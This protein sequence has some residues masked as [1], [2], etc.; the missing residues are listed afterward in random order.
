[1]PKHVAPRGSI[2]YV[3][4]F[5]QTLLGDLSV[6]AD[7]K[8][9]EAA[10]WISRPE[11]TLLFNREDVAQY[12]NVVRQLLADFAKNE[13]LSRRS[14]EALLEDAIFTAWD[15]RHESRVQSDE[16]VRMAAT[17]LKTRLSAKPVEY[18]VFVPVEGFEPKELP[19]TFGGIRFAAFGSAQARALRDWRPARSKVWNELKQDDL[20]KQPSAAAR[21]MARDFATAQRRARAAVREAMDCLNFVGSMHPYNHAWLRFPSEASV[22]RVVTAG[23]A[24]GGPACV[25]HDACGPLG[26]FALGQLREAPRTERLL[27]RLSPLLDKALTIEP[28]SRGRRRSTA[29]ET[30]LAAVE[31]AGR[32]SIEREREQQFLLYAISLETAV[33][34]VQGNELTHRL[35]M[36]VARLLSRKPEVRA[37][38]H[39]RV[40]RLYSIRSRIV[41]SGFYEVADDDLRLLKDVVARTLLTLLRRRSLLAAKPDALDEM[42]KR[43]EWGR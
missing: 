38:I 35:A 13:D 3:E 34:P 5:L 30:L 12:S 24:R 10:W 21:V 36:R 16:R 40:I 14:V 15:P 7:P 39:E 18:L 26:T 17:D 43:L 20:W 41:H 22:A 11:G 31:R 9:S 29:G 32:A 42:L 37:R 23:A 28:S 4:D 25:S 1:M 27:R 8:F 6:A 2:S 19:F 33:L